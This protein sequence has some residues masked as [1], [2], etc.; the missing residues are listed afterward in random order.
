MFSNLNDLLRYCEK[1]CVEFINF[2]VV[3]RAGRWHQLSIPAARFNEETLSEGIG[4]DGSSYGFLT[5]EK[6]DMER[7]VVQ[8]VTSFMSSDGLKTVNIMKIFQDIGLTPQ[9]PSHATTVPG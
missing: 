9:M 8:Q 1:E 3:D 7:S 4:F 5:V 6:S 2:K